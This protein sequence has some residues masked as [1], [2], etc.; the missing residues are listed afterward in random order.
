MTDEELIALAKSRFEPLKTGKSEKSIGE[1]AGEFRLGR[2]SVQPA[3]RKA[4]QRGLVEFRV[5]ESESRFLADIDYRVRPLEDELVTRYGVPRAIVARTLE[6]SSD[7][8]HR[9]LGYAMAVHFSALVRNGSTIGLGSGRG[10]YYTVTGLIQRPRIQAKNVTLMSLTGA[11]FPKAHS[12][13]LNVIL[14]ADYH[15]GLMGICFMQ[16]LESQRVVAH[17]IAAQEYRPDTWL[18]ESE[19]AHHVPSLAIVGLGVL[20]GRHKFA[21][22]VQADN[23]GA[24][25][26]P[27]FDPLKRLVKLVERYSDDEYCC[28][29][30]VCHHL[31][32]V[33]PP[34]NVRIA[35][36]DRSKIESLISTINRQL[37]TLDE[38]QLAQVGGLCVIAGTP[39]K[40]WAIRRLLERH[41]QGRINIQAIS[42]DETTATGLLS[43]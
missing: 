3:I 4:F 14:D 8:V 43:D 33:D 30:D 40:K 12:E 36:K 41:Q 21:L 16:Q 34:P 24:S 26:K 13:T 32:F 9:D 18:A 11:V 1:L 10:P 38:D 5:V 31:F 23:P 27:I 28:V 7:L 35:D 2:N 17:P 29:A 20:R 6:K 15:T 19:F 22:A 42:I 37:L 39:E 25:L